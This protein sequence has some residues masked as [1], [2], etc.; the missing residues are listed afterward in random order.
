M[1]SKDRIAGADVFTLTADVPTFSDARHDISAREAMWVRVR[2][3]DGLE[4]WGEAAV[5]G[6][7]APVTATIIAEEL[8]P[9]LR[10]EDPD[11]IHYLWEKLYQ[12]TA[13]HGRR[14]AIVAA[15]GALDI[16]LWDIMAKRCN[17]PLVNILGRQADRVVPYASAGFY[18]V[19]KDLDALRA[20]YERLRGW[21]FRAFKMKV[22]RQHRE[23]SRVWQR[24]DTY[25]L[26]EDIERVHVVRETIGPESILLIDANT[27]WDTVTTV[28]F[29][30]AVED[31]RPFF[32][33]EPVSADLFN[34]AIEIRSRTNVRIAGFETEYT[35]YAYRELLASGAVDVV[36]PDPC[37]CGGLSE[38]R[39]IAAMA[40]AW[41][42]IC[43]PH[44][45]SSMLSFL[46]NTHFVASLDN[47][48]L[49]EWDS[50]GNP[51]MDQLIR[52]A[53]A[54]NEDGTF[55]VPDAPGIGFDPQLEGLEG[56][57]DRLTI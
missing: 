19:G 46:T 43:V 48:F 29:L 36:Q 42:R 16:A 20:E 5:W 14:G 45:F 55:T 37:W 23:W 52:A 4:G 38:A 13:Q 30:R 50:S 12:Q 56:T 35:R 2:T 17:Q 32:M 15:M 57:I 25:T 40:S 1:T 41:G 24:P 3:Q 53:D 22:G 39:R 9:M 28:T 33:E 51:W 8:F 47:G 21:G 7:P 6:G 27:E 44:S 26:D 11:A 18:A 31:A 49:V 54:L 10:G 34:Q